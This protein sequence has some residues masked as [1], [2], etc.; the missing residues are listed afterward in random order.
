M[1]RLSYEETKLSEEQDK[2]VQLLGYRSNYYNMTF[3]SFLDFYSFKIEDDNIV[4]FND[5][6]IPYEDFNNDDYSYVPSIL[7]SFGE[8]DL[9]K[10]IENEIKSQLK[11][12]EEQKIAEKEDIK[13]QIELLTKKLNNYA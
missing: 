11:Q 6:R 13:R 1:N 2:Y 3:Q 7:L 5:D 12:Q 4:V 8:K 10:W 9:E